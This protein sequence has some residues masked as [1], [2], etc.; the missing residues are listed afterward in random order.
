MQFAGFIEVGWGFRGALEGFG[1][2]L[3]GRSPGVG[4]GWG[5]FRRV[6]AGAFG[7]LRG[8]FAGRSR[9]APPAL[10][11][12]YGQNRPMDLA[13]MSWLVTVGA[14]LIA[15]LVLVIQGYIGY[16]GVT[17]AVAICAAVNLF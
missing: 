10:V 9:G 5:G 13:R 7:L 11:Q 4:G 12:S 1:G 17:L 16:A 3:A 8:C 2:A 6:L 15:V 14:C